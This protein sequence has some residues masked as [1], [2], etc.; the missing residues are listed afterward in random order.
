MR[1][2]VEMDRPVCK[3]QLRRLSISDKL[4]ILLV[5]LL[6]SLMASPLSPAYSIQ[7]NASTV[8]ATASK[9]PAIDIPHEALLL[10]SRDG[11]ELWS[12][13]ADQTRAMASLTKIMTAMVVLDRVNLDETI[14]V[15]ATDIAT[16]GS[17]ANLLPGETM[18]VRQALE[19]LLLVS[20]NEVANA[21]ARH[22]AGSAEEF[23]AIMNDRALRLGMSDTRFANPHGIDQSGHY[24]TA[25]DLAI[26]ARH[27]MK[28]D[29]IRRI[30]K[31]QYF[32]PDGDGPRPRQQNTNLLIGDY[33]AATG[34]KTGWTSRA[35]FCLISSA[36]INGLELYA[37]VL[38]TPN[39][40]ARF[41]VASQVMDWGFDNLAYQ[42]VVTQGQQFGSVQ[43]SDYLD[44][45]VQ[46]V[47]SSSFSDYVFAPAGE[48]TAEV[49]IVPEIE[50]PV[51][52]GDRLGT[53]RLVQGDRLIYQTAL[54]SGVSVERPG[55]FERVWIA[56]QRLFR[57]QKG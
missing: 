11:R 37:V 29:E 41:D 39:E 38:G 56:I 44:R 5:S 46:A 43:V 35:G 24:S 13:N 48:I 54:V 8:A 16:G 55:V 6:I 19:A 30:S 27:A 42:S 7:P 18:T 2:L 12:A 45:S 40:K 25:A 34:L 4:H 52:A 15:T 53:V 20:G 10:V 51:N 17:N 23:V 9:D 57:P 49:E 26:L 50:A 32:D 33:P 21:L 3:T 22:V 47:S 28:V 1:S 14:Q 31:M 36:S